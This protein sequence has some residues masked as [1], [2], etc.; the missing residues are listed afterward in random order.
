MPVAALGSDRSLRLLKKN[1]KLG[2][3]L[4][5]R[6]FLFLFRIKNKNAAKGAPLIKLLFRIY[7]V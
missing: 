7:I 5:T 2:N 6:L 1:K 4:I 3:K